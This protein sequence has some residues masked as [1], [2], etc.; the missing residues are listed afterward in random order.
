LIKP[1]MPDLILARPGRTGQ[2]ILEYCPMTERKVIGP[3]RV[4]MRFESN[5]NE[6]GPARPPDQ[7]QTGPG[8]TEYLHNGF[9]QHRVGRG[10][11]GCWLFTPNDP[12]PES[13]PVVVFF[14]GWLGVNPINYGAWIV[15]LVRRGNVV[16]YPVYQASF[17]TPFEGMMANAIEGIR[18]GLQRLKDRGPVRPLPDRWAFAGH[19]LGG[20]IASKCA[21]LAPGP[22]P[23]PRVLM[24]V[25]AGW[26]RRFSVSLK[27]LRQV[28]P[29]V[30]ALVVAGE[31]DRHL[32][33]D[34]PLAIYNA[35]SGI[36]DENRNIILVRSDR[37][38]FPPLIADH[39]APLSERADV[40][41]RLTPQ[42]A[43]RREQALSAAGLRSA[44]ADALDF[45][46]HWKLLDAAISAAFHGQ[47]REKALGNTPAQR[48]MGTWS[49]GIPVKELSVSTRPDGRFTDS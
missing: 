30:L 29:H 12:V 47:H 7:P 45:Y 26:G 31:E 25:Q 22:L 43:L 16:L 49:D 1:A 14:H 18:L 38:G 15:H 20:L 33:F 42:A 41:L 46:G 2:R 35:L 3:A 4:P 40:G 23:D 24:L 9:S 6:V 8:G 19:S 13:T 48:Y 34:Q 32:P 10:E 11:Q 27:D 44:R 5:N 21:S 39:S 28:S 36:P 17:F 37:H